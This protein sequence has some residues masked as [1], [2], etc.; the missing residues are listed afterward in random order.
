MPK[1]QI[2]K[3]AHVEF[4]TKDIRALQ[5]ALTETRVGE[6]DQVITVRK[7]P[8]FP[9]TDAQVV[10]NGSNCTITIPQTQEKHRRICRL[11][12]AK[13]T[14][15]V[16]KGEVTTIIGEATELRSMGLDAED[17]T[18]KVT[19]KKYEQCGTC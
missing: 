18:I 3:K 6:D 2:Y 7:P 16:R 9:L 5:A 14:L 10:F 1:M 19:I 8:K 15:P 17:S 13:L 11:T 4:D 12:N